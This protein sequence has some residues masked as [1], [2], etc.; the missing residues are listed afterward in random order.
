MGR[1]WMFHVRSEGRVERGETKATRSSDR[2]AKRE[3]S[4]VK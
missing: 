2:D 4:G 1:K 3:Q